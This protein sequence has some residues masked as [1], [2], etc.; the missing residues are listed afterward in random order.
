M[1]L[2]GEGKRVS[3]EKLLGSGNGE[4]TGKIMVQWF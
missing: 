2:F 1:G 4:K 3:M